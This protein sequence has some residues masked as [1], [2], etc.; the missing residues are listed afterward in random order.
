MDA[1]VKAEVAAVRQSASGLVHKTDV[2][3]VGGGLA[4]SLTAAM[5]GR[6]S[7][8]AILVDPHTEYPPDFRCEKLD[9]DQVAI[10]KK[11]GLS[12]AVLQA[13]T[14][15]REAWIARNGR[16]VEKRPGDQ[17]GIYYA[18]LV[19]TVRAE[20]P[21][22]TRFL[23]GKATALSVGADRQSVTLSS[24]D[25]IDARLVVLA[26]GLNISLRDSL[27]LKREILSPCHSISI[28]FD[29]EPAGRPFAF[30]AL[31][32]YAERTSDNAALITMFPIG[33]VMRAN[34]FVYRDMDDPWLSRMRKEPQ[35][36]L[37]ELMP[38]LR[39]LTGEFAVVGPVKIRP[40]DLYATRGHLQPGIVLV[41][42][43]YATSC[44]AAGTGARKVLTDVERLCNVH[45]PQWLRTA[46]MD[47]EKIAAFY[48][49][50][51]KQGCDQFSINKAYWLKAFCTD[52]S[53]RWQLRRQGKFFLHLVRGWLRKV[54]PHTRLERAQRSRSIPEPSGG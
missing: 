53:L 20:I 32:Y 15:D 39:A 1:Q 3:I 43:A 12:S 22:Q 47:T 16:L 23:H 44:P 6:A 2:A 54:E 52:P 30:P 38:G 17:Q 25:V 50:P 31:T 28:G 13:T 37:F 29:M 36:T 26:N 49:D 9:G 21:S 4:G 35:Q 8:D 27:G 18:P 45:I 40:V 14:P 42:D 34:L 41:G 24:G 7:I 48:D 51:V 33:Q 5:L 11:T 19:N 46:G 10:L